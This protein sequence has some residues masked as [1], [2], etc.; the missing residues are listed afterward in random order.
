MRATLETLKPTLILLKLAMILSLLLS[1]GSL[2]IDIRPHV[3]QSYPLQTADSAGPVPAGSWAKAS[4]PVSETA[5][6]ECPCCCGASCPITA[7]LSSLPA[8]AAFP[9]SAVVDPTVTADLATAEP[10]DRY[11][12][13]IV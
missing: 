5:N 10:S 6:P 3:D 9:I 4:A 11:K 8:M 12:P 2:K 13:P 1:A 7:I